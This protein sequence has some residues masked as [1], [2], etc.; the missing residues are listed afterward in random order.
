MEAFLWCKRFIAES[1]EGKV[2]YWVPVCVAFGI[3]LYF[4]LPHEPS[5]SICLFFT[6]FLGMICTDRYKRQRYAQL[7]VFGVLG[8]VVLG[9]TLVTLRTQSLDTKFIEKEGLYQVEAEVENILP[10]EKGQRVILKNILLEDE[11][12]PFAAKIRLSSYHADGINIGDRV[13][14][15]TKL[16]PPS[17]PVYPGGFDFRRYA[18]YRGWGA[19]GFTLS[20]FEVIE[21]AEAGHVTDFFKNWRQFINEKLNAIDDEKS[22]GVAKALI[23]GQRQAVDTEVLEDIR[24][25]GIAHLL[26]IS[27]LHIGLVAGFVFFLIRGVLASFPSI[28]LRYPIKKIA[29]I[30]GMLAAVT[31]M[32]I[33]GAPVPTQRAVLMTGLVFLAVIVDRT[34]ISFRLAA[35]S[36]LVIMVI[37][38][39]TVAEVSFQLSFAAVLSLIAFYEWA[40]KRLKSYFYQQGFFNKLGVYFMGLVITT[41]IASIATAPLTLFHFQH[42]AVYSVLANMVAVPIVSFIVMPLALI[43]VALMPFHME[44]WALKGMEKGIEAVV[45]SAR[46]VAHLDGAVF[47]SPRMASLA[48]S[49]VVLGALILMLTNKPLKP[50]GVVLIAIGSIWAFMPQKLP[51]VLLSEDASLVSYY[52]ESKKE[53]R[54][55][56]ISRD[57]YIIE[58]WAEGYGL[59]DSDIKRMAHCDDN[60]CVFEK[61]GLRFAYVKGKAGLGE[62]CQKANILMLPFKLS[63]REREQHC[64]RP[65][66]IIDRIDVWKN[67]AYAIYVSGATVSIKTVG[68]QVH[69]RPWQQ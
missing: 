55:N 67:G 10:Y 28:A 68:G 14:V 31:Y 30:G 9:M 65:T 24:D 3:L 39:E 36:A 5:L 15:L 38:P 52:D 7:S 56:Q 6:L 57:K 37:R 13:S 21:P 46:Y 16:R 19:V 1:F 34:S 63:W 40:H 29:A 45:D 53:L 49:I 35:F 58:S 47:H 18:F 59:Q 20:A 66:H 12:T 43:A 48:I 42:F 17:P 60:G 61:D 27:G 33:V 64:S 69:K 62:E 25:A 32:L 4:C 26:A 50:C 54:F 23:L 11:R 41:V 51:S 8:F 2:F 22:R 44:G